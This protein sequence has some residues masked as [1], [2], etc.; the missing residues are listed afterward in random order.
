[1]AIAAEQT[2]TTPFR[3]P[4]SAVFT[5]N[6]AT[7]AL[8][9][10]A[11]VVIIRW[12]IGTKDAAAPLGIPFAQYAHQLAGVATVG[13]LFLRCVAL[14]RDNGPAVQHLANMAARWGWIWVASTLVRIV[15][16]A[17]ELFGVPVTQVLLQDNLLPVLAS[18][19]AVHTQVLT[20]WVALLVALFGARLSGT[21]PSGALALLGAAALLP[22]GWV[23]P[24]GHQAHSGGDLHRLVMAAVAI[25]VVAAALWL[26]GLVALAVHLRPFTPQLRD[27]AAKFSGTAALCALTF[28]LSALLQ[29]TL[30]LGWSGLWV[31]TRGNLIVAQAVALLL[32]AVVGYRHR[33]RTSESAGGRGVRSVCGLVGSELLLTAATV[34]VAGLVTV[35]A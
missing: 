30:A 16:S 25:Q 26:G 27:A 29:T 33:R 9:G 4:W 31:T 6:A 14:G 3:R 19:D 17:S 34:A 5:A 12:W 1:M 21:A 11:S 7:V 13:L 24:S 28:G 32:L 8:T 35:P 2:A 10:M 18:S 22:V 23:V 15:V 20:L